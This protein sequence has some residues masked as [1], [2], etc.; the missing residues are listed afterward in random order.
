MGVRTTSTPKSYFG[1]FKETGAN[2][3]YV[4]PQGVSATGGN[5]SPPSGLTPGDGYV[6]HVFTASGSLVVASGT[7][8]D[9]SALIL[10]GGGG[11]GASMGGGGGSGGALYDN[12]SVPIKP[13][14]YT[15]TVGAGGVRGGVSGAGS[16]TNNGGTGGNS[17]FYHPDDPTPK[18]A[19]ALG[20]GGGGSYT[21][22]HPGADG[23]PGGSGG[24]CGGNY[25]TSPHTLTN[26]GTQPANNPDPTIW[27]TLGN[28]SGAGSGTPYGGAGGGGLQTA[29]TGSP[30]PT[31]SGG[32]GGAGYPLPIF[33]GPG[34]GLPAIPSDV[35][36]AGGQGNGYPNNPTP[37][38]SPRDNIGGQGG[39]G[40]G[41][42][43]GGSA[44]TNSGSG[45]GGGTYSS[46]PGGSGGSGVV[47]V[48]YPA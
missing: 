42:Y 39:P 46:G 20:G 25:P 7:A 17:Q 9:G 48:R 18:R 45:G 41:P 10:A 16:P 30:L 11:G 32:P 44:V 15:V 8:T 19:T 12:G 38:R 36:G 2:A 27:T 26:P 22:H 13:G 33:P 40:Q 3:D 14:T 43:P 37:H 21:Y 4:A 47:I 23:A 31:T 35:W 24:G 6:Y 29:G 5:Q 28:P 1:R 34:L